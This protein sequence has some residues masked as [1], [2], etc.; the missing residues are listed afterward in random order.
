MPS[1]L[2][3]LQLPTVIIF[4]DILM[5]Y[6]STTSSANF[7]ALRDAVGQECNYMLKRVSHVAAVA[8]EWR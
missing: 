3:V 1:N 6:N 4:L 8:H 2:L 5:A 7:T